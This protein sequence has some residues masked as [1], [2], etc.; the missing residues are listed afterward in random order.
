MQIQIHKE[1]LEKNLSIIQRVV[2]NTAA[3]PALRGVKCT[4]YKNQITFEGT[5]IEMSASIQ[6][7]HKCDGEG[8]FLIPLKTFLDVIKFSFGEITLV[9]TQ[10]ILTIKSGKSV[11]KISLLP[12]DEFPLLP[13]KSPENPYSIKT[14]HL[15]QGLTSVLYAVSQSTIKPELASVFVYTDDVFLVF[16]GTDSFRLAEK[17]ISFSGDRDFPSILIPSKNAHEVVSLLTQTTEDSVSL[18]VEEDICTIATDTVQFT[19]RLISG[20]FPDYKK[21]I[22]KEYTTESIL[23]KDDIVQ[24]LKKM[25]VVADVSKQVNFDIAPQKG[26]ITLTSKSSTVGEVEDCLDGTVKGQDLVLNFNQRYVLDCFQSIPMDSVHFGFGG[27]G[28]PLVIQGVS[29]KSFTYLVMP[30]NK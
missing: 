22:P 7:V 13:Q 21:I 11:T 10:Q 3:I 2:N 14:Q 26:H 1:V 9:F 17:R 12:N 18:F 25:S 8:V 24:A 27:P 20:V 30:M 28:R 29:D 19:T 4:V 6:M 16:V 15:I 5:N 23:L